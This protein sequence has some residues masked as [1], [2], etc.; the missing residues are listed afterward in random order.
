M[1]INTQN[2]P[3][4]LA[5]ILFVFGALHAYNLVKNNKTSSFYL[6]KK[7]IKIFSPLLLKIFISIC[8]GTTFIEAIEI[9]ETS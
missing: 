5:A 9:L 8:I 2:K 3:N 4:P 6:I 7:G 1:N